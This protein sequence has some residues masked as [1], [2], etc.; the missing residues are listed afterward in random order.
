MKISSDAWWN[1]E[2]A[3]CSFFFTIGKKA[4]D[5]TWKT[6]RTASK[7]TLC[8]HWAVRVA[9]ETLLINSV[10]PTGHVSTKPYCLPVEIHWWSFVDVLAIDTSKNCEITFTDLCMY[11]KYI[12]GANSRPGWAAQFELIYNVHPLI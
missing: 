7:G 4:A 5:G 3:P 12:Y 10:S 9:E 8:N 1:N 6:R 11:L 2:I